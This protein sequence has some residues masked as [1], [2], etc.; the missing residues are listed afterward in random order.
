MLWNDTK[1]QLS[2][3]PS[4][5]NSK[6]ED[7]SLR[8]EQVRA[9]LGAVAA[10]GSAIFWVYVGDDGQWCYRREGAPGKMTFESR[11]MCLSKLV[12]EIMRCSSYRL[13]LEGPDGRIREESFNGL[14]AA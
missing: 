8:V 13:F 7:Q 6:E 10:G 12:V 4:T 1:H 9:A 5:P 11:R 3:E 14:T 2:V